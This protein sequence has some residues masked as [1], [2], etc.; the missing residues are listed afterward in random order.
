MA[1]KNFHP[2]VASW[3]RGAFEAP[4]EIQTEAWPLCGKIRL[5][6]P[7]TGSGKT[8]TAFLASIDDL[9]KKSLDGELPDKTKIV[10]VSPLKALS[11]DIENN[12]RAPLKGIREE[13]DRRGIYC[14]RD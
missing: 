9:V 11:N 2:A 6:P 1:L 7:P 12:L 8:L 5:S 13:L 14:P 10:Y 3:F 4:T